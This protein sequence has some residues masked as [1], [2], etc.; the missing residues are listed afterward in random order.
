M[1]G[2]AGAGGGLAFELGAAFA[3]LLDVADVD[4]EEV[5][6]VVVGGRLDGVTDLVEAS[7]AEAFEVV[8]GVTRRAVV[9]LF[10]DAFGEGFVEGAVEGVDGVWFSLALEPC[11]AEGGEVVVEV[12]V[13]WVGHVG[14]PTAGRTQSACQGLSPLCTVSGLRR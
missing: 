2:G 7:A 14:P 13:L 6:V 1:G 11:G 4:A 12:A 8:L 3:E 5:E 9:W 10:G